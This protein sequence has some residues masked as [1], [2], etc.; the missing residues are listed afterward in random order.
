MKAKNTVADAVRMPATPRGANG[1]KWPPSP[2]RP[3]T[4]PPR[5]AVSR[6]TTDLTELSELRAEADD[7]LRVATGDLERPDAPR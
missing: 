1:W 7:V 4:R 5:A 2:A 3:R 6:L